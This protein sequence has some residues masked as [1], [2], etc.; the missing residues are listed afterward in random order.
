MMLLCSPMVVVPAGVERSRKR[1]MIDEKSGIGLP[2]HLPSFACDGPCVQ[3]TPC[4]AY[5]QRIPRN[6]ERRLSHF[7]YGL[8]RTHG[9]SIALCYA[10]PQTA[11]LGRDCQRRQIE[12]DWDGNGPG[13]G[14]ALERGRFIGRG[15]PLSGMR[16]SR[17]S[18]PN[19]NRAR[20]LKW[21]Q[22]AAAIGA[23]ATSI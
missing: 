15:M 22:K 3:T 19:K 9:R 20:G 4:F 13:S 17:L 10:G 16:G 7:S 11:A 21:I 18:R 1:R 6:C 2:R 5:L 12:P 8:Q 23:N 14:Q